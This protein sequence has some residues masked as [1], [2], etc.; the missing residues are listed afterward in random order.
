M[1]GTGTSLPLWLNPIPNA[2]RDQALDCWRAGDWC[3]FLSKA[4]HDDTLALVM[5][6]IVAF[7]D[8]GYYEAALVDAY[9][10]G[11]TTQ[12]DF[13][14]DVLRSLFSLADR[15]RLMEAGNP[16]PGPGP[17]TL[18]RGVAGPLKLRRVRG[19]SWSSSVMAAAWFA[20]F[21]GRIV[22][23][24]ALYRVTVS[25]SDVLFYTNDRAEEEFVILLS[26]K[27]RPVRIAL[28]DNETVEQWHRARM[29]AHTKEG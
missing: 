19:F 28:P 2:L 6:N 1:K 23:S 8:A 20:M 29:K 10:G 27:A 22:G 25:S 17:F 5:H 24:P 16:L 18:Y 9:A 11:R 21:F 15:A 13:S 4:S 26:K 7:R 14:N 12:A 3:G